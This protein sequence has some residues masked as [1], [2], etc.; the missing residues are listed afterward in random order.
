M[1]PHDRLGRHYTNRSV[2]GHRTTS[3][4]SEGTQVRLIIIKLERRPTFNRVNPVSSGKGR[5]GGVH[6]NV[7][8]VRNG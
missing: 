5:H 4:T 8:K 1:L 2:I 7:F 3:G 6:P